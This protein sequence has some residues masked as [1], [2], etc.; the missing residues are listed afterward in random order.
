MERVAQTSTSRL[1]IR[2]WKPIDSSDY[3]V[4]IVLGPGLDRPVY[5]NR[6]RKRLWG[7]PLECGVAVTA[8]APH[9]NACVRGRG[10]DLM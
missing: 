8:V 7:F 2:R 4:T 10:R 6:G 1:C 3:F 5:R 9:W